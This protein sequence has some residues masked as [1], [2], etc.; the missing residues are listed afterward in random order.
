M[1]YPVIDMMGTGRRIKELRKQHNL[2]VADIRDYLG[3]ESE[4]AIYKWQR[5]DSLPTLDN[6]IA[7]AKMCNTTMDD[8]IQV[9]E[10]EDDSPLPFILNNFYFP[11]IANNLQTIYKQSTNNPKLQVH[12]NLK[13]NLQ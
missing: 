12:S 6:L 13:R 4:Q 10:R 11:S 5:G 1:G 2:K 8:I 3:L 9:I 7:F